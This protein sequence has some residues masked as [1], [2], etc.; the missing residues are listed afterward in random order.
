LAALALVWAVFAPA[1]PASAGTQPVT[2]QCVSELSALFE[3]PLSMLLLVM[4]T[5]QG[6]VG[7]SSLNKNGTRDYGPM[8]I[9]SIWLPRLSALGVTE[10][11]LRDHGCVNVAAGAWLLR[12]HLSEAKD[13]LEALS[14]YHSRKPRLKRRYL[15]AA[16]A[17]AKSLDVAGTLRRAN[18]GDSAHRAGPPKAA[19]AKPAERGNTGPG[20]QKAEQRPAAPE[21]GGKKA[22]PQ[23]KAGGG[24]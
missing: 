4:D 14:L 19:P 16:L 22:P 2:W 7:K 24:Q 10:E 9:N 11:L 21:R 13:P 3:V 18:N 8:Q 23:K 6:R 1:A 20:G 15:A 5:E 17:R 12:A